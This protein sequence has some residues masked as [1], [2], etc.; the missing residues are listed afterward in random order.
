MV[1][2]V[3]ISD[4]LKKEGIAVQEACSSG[5]AA[6]QR[7]MDLLE[8]ASA[9]N[10]RE[11]YRA[12]LLEKGKHCPFAM[13][14]GIAILHADGDFVQQAAVAVLIVKAGESV[15][16]NDEPCDL[17]MMLASEKE[18]THIKLLSS[19]AEL[20]MDDAFCQRLRE[21]ED[22]REVQVAFA[23]E[24]QKLTTPQLR[25]VTS[26]H[27]LHIRPANRLAGVLS[28]YDGSLHILCGDKRVNAKSVMSLMSAGIR[29]GDSLTLEAKGLQSAELLQQAEQFFNM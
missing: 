19:L 14:E 7:L 21:A 16:F 27:P 11:A 18:L 23:A 2:Y 13:G 1:I 5:E 25:K 10:D 4:Y 12:T 29:R 17:L 8:A 9:L 6:T 24:E 26:R 28:R 15:L 22:V 3:K 20:L